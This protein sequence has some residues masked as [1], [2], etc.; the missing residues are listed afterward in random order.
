VPGLGK[1]RSVAC[2][3]SA[4]RLLD[5]LI[6]NPNRA[7][8]V[9]TE[10]V[11]TEWHQNVQQVR[12]KAEDFLTKIDRIVE[13]SYQAAAYAGTTLPAFH[14]LSAS[15]LVDDV[16]ALS[17]A[18]LNLAAVLDLDV[19]HSHAALSRVMTKRRPSQD[20]HIKD[21]IH[22]EHYLELARQLRAAGFPD[23]VVLVS[24][25]RKDYWDGENPQ[26]HPDLS[27]EIGDPGVRIRFF[28]SLEAAMGFLHI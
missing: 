26:I 15:T 25:N 24:R 23:E 4:R 6:A 7:Q 8:V 3:D 2:L 10:L 17:T 18:I 16:V 19:I 13:R 9:I 12:S 5:T 22:F 14:P 11:G 1:P 20:G 27:A 21:S 28:G